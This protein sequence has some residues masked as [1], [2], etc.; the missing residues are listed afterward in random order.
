MEI[1]TKFTI[2]SEEGIKNLFFLRNTRIS[3]MYAGSVEEAKLKEYREKLSNHREAVNE[4]NNLTTQ[5]ITVFVK[6]VPAG[7]A[8][9]KQSTAP[10]ALK[11]KKASHLDAFYIL[12][13]YDGESVRDALWK[14]CR[15]VT[16]MSDALWI[17]M[18]QTD[19]LLPYLQS[20]GF[21][22]SDSA[23]M[24]PFAKASYILVYENND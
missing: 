9:L 10:E 17:E 1:T 7:Y 6:D 8:L 19:L 16:R 3:A 11:G 14:K 4:L 22:I 21:T 15:S 2:A 12:P 24:K 20:C 18:L 5:M 23:E 13:E